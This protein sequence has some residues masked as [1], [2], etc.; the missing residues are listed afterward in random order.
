MRFRRCSISTWRVRRAGGSCCAWRISTRRAAGPEF[1]AAIYEDL[2]WLGV[3]WEQ[4]VRRQS[5]HL[6][7]YRAALEKLQ[8]MRL[9]FPSFESRAEIAHMVGD[10][11]V[12]ERWPRDPDG[13]PVYP[14]AARR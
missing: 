11:D 10:R 1:E 6:D 8:A 7:E 14:G 2:A 3:E 12:R 4:P 5:E 13:V 9:T